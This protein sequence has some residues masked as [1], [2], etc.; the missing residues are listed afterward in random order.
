M[1]A[2]LEVIPG[3]RHV[4]GRL[5]TLHVVVARD[6]DPPFSVDAAVFEEDTWLA[7]STVS[8]IVRAPGHPVRVMTSVWESEPE[9]PGSVVVRSGSPL[10][11][12]AI[13]HDLNADPTCT[14]DWVA[15]ALSGVFHEARERG[16]QAIKLPLLGTQHGRLP[17][18][19]FM[20]V[21]RE[22]L[23]D[24]LSSAPADQLTLRRLWLVRDS[25][26]GEGLLRTLG[27]DQKPSR[28]GA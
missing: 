18:P 28:N 3:G 12:L 26:P 11:L 17:A 23:G 1:R 20:A 10:R 8:P 2:R 15:A 21:L 16:V 27:A 13:V 25:E 19:R 7:L 6:D 4:S 9:A 5:G 14:E 22:V 24:F